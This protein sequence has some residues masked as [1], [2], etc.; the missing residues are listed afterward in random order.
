MAQEV[1]LRTAAGII[2]A[3]KFNDNVSP[4]KP[5]RHAAT[6]VFIR[7][8]QYINPSTTP[9]L[10]ATVRFDVNKDGDYLDKVWLCVTMSALTPNG[11]ATFA[12]YCDW[13]GYA[14]IRQFRAIYGPQTLQRISKEELFI[15]A[16]RF[17]NDEEY[18]HNARM[19]KGGIADADRVL[20]ASQPQIL[21]VPIHTLWL[22]NSEPQS[23]C[24]QG[25][26]NRI[27][28][29]IDFEPSVNLVQQDNTGTLVSPTSESAFF[30]STPYG[31]DCRLGIEY[32]H[33]TTS[34][35]DAVVAMYRQRKGLR[36]LIT[37]IQRSPG[38]IFAAA[39]NV[40]QTQS[41]QLINMTQPVYCGFTLLRWVND[42]TA[43]YTSAAINNVYGRNWFNCNGWLQPQGTGLPLRPMFINMQLKSGN[44]NLLYQAS[45]YDY[46]D[47]KSAR[48][49]KNGVAQVRGIPSFSWSH[50]PTLPN[51]TLG[52]VDF[53]VVNQPLQY[54]VGNTNPPYA[55]FGAWATQ[56]IGFSSALQLDNI[57]FT[58]NNIDATNYD[59]IRPFN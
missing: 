47:D 28:F 15:W 24:L 22:N 11:G 59:L 38:Q 1:F 8:E 36:Y 35:R 27:S 20:E 6:A 32:V 57:Y 7:E 44:N 50:Q 4:F 23:L 19:V 2:S 18:V 55:T 48:Y 33:V 10:G 14:L 49:F 42:L 30:N 54:W 43:T 51:A 12:R 31:V 9:A 34:E 58:Y 5:V 56:D 13:L 45:I 46:L 21:K 3:D 37:D 53:S 29:E 41:F 16:Q 26:G 17:L 52:S 25:L 39:S 40:N